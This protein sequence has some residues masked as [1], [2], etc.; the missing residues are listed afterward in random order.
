MVLT[1]N[2]HP[3]RWGEVLHDDDLADAIVDRIL[4]RGRLLRLDG[5][6]V[7]TKHIPV[8]ELAGGEQVDPGNRRV[9]GIDAAEFPERTRS[10]HCRS[11]SGGAG[12]ICRP[13][14]TRRAEG[15]PRTRRGSSGYRG[16]TVATIERGLR[17]SSGA[18]LV[19]PCSRSLQIWDRHTDGSQDPPLHLGHPRRRQYTP[20]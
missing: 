2:K 8:D 15:M 11:T 20:E 14:E 4:E 7:R 1:T 5:P 9:S 3:K 13:D 18:S 17:S 12:P 16:P 10:G 19:P 6:S